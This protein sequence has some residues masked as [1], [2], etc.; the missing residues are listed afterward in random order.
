MET[1]LPIH[2][3]TYFFLSSYHIR[4]RFTHKKRTSLR[5][6]SSLP[7]ECKGHKIICSQLLTLREKLFQFLKL[8]FWS[9]VTTA[10]SFVLVVKII[11]KGYFSY[12]YRIMVPIPNGT[13]F[14]VD[15]LISASFWKRSRKAVVSGVRLE[16]MNA[17]NSLQSSFALTLVKRGPEQRKGYEVEISVLESKLTISQLLHPSMKRCEK[18][19]T[20]FNLRFLSRQWWPG[21]QERRIG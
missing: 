10:A 4:N 3:F 5:I 8:W 16:P 17:F 6:N 12:F 21:Y 20:W 14:Y 11:Q 18:S 15:R 2:R 1:V 9:D 7:D 13:T 19:A